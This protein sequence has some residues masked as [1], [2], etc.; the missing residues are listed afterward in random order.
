MLKLLIR[1][2]FILLSIT[3]TVIELKVTKSHFHVYLNLNLR[4]YGQLFVLVCYYTN[5]LF[6]KPRI[7][8]YRCLHLKQH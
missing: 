7:P 1:K 3:S 6:T 4:S 5:T 8:I 2:N